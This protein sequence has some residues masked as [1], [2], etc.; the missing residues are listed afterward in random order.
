MH[1]SI[2]KYVQQTLKII[3]GLLLVHDMYVHIIYVFICTV[4][5]SV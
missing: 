5:S 1:T 3:H 4:R 2:D